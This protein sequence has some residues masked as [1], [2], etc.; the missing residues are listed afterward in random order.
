MAP[1]KDFITLIDTKDDRQEYLVFKI[2]K[3][4]KNNFPA[5]RNKKNTNPKSDIDRIII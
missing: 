5:K 1:L 4:L 3:L 2:V